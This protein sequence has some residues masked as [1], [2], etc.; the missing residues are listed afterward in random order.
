MR[1][2]LI[3]ALV[4]LA[5]VTLAPRAEAQT[6]VPRV[7]WACYVP[8]TGTTY[9]VR[10]TDLKQDCQKAT[11]VLFSWSETGPQGPQGPQGMEGPAGAQGPAGPAGPQGATGPQGPAGPAGGMDWSQLWTGSESFSV[12]ARGFTTSSSYA[13]SYV[14]CPAGKRIL[15]GSWSLVDNDV[16]KRVRSRLMSSTV[17]Y[18]RNQ[19]WVSFYNEGETALVVR[20]MIGCI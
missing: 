20:L 13:T 11:H 10:E 15:T 2:T 6:T 1:R 4:A 19:Y 12:P 14:E 5:A 17:D 8:G 9:R 18:V 16:E 3:A 7:F